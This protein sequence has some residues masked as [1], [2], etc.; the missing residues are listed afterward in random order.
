MHYTFIK[1][2]QG[3]A[4]WLAWRRGGFGGS[5]IS[6]LMGE[7]RFRSRQQVIAEKHGHMR[8]ESSEAMTRGTRLEPIAREAYNRRT[9]HQVEPA[10]IQH[11][12][13]T[14]ARVSLDGIRADGTRAVEIKC[15]ES[16]FDKVVR[17][18]RVPGYYFG[19]LQHILFVTGL[20]VVDYW[21]FDP[22]KGGI[23]L[24]VRKDENYIARI[25]ETCEQLKSEL[26]VC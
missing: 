19:Q 15:G 8:S 18:R 25:I 6:S 11:N 2:E 21:A 1:H 20:D 12:Q 14:W 26:P 9:G 23:L 4:E 22:R 3:S 16:S 7:N 17:S 10:C 24:E 13:Y 5:D